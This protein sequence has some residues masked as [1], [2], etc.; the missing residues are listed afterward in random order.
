MYGKPPQPE[1]EEKQE[2]TKIYYE[3][4]AEQ[5]VRNETRGGYEPHPSGPAPKRDVKNNVMITSA[6]IVPRFQSILVERFRNKLKMRGGK[7]MVGMRRQFKIMDDNNSGTLDIHE[8]RKGIKDFQ[9]GIEGEDVDN[10]FKAFDLN[11]NGDIDYDEFVRS[12]VGPMNQFRVQLVM[13]AFDKI[14]YNGD[15]VLTVEDIKG[16]YD[17]SRHPEVKSGKKTEDEVL[18]EFLETFEMHHNVMNNNQSDGKVSREEFIEYYTNISAS[19][20]NDAYFD[21]MMTNAWQL[22]GNGGT[23]NMAFA[24]SQRTVTHVSARDCW[25]QDHH[26]NL[27]GT[28]KATPFEKN[29]NTHWQTTMKGGHTDEV[30]KQEGIQGAGS[31]TFGKSPFSYK[32]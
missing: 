32:N 8:F 11:G 7:G 20:D 22:D 3:V 16:K 15:G 31:A 10:L 29:N 1:D 17:A 19:V 24:G 21:L 26:R 30:Y 12:V 25:R 4:K 18:R 2:R 23:N 27:F 28:D 9:V 5:P 14:D 6:P 13:K